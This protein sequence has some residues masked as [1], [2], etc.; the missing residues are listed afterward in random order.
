MPGTL[1]LYATTEG[2]TARIAERIARALR[3]RGHAAETCPAT[4]APQGL[5]AAGYNGVV[6]GASIHYGRHPAYLRSLVRS[7]RAAL[8]ARPS[9]FFSVSLSGGGPGAKP[10]AARRYLEVFLRQ[11]GWHPQQTATFAGALPYSR[12]GAFKRRL[13]VAFVGL[14]GGDTD[15]SRD[16][17]YTDWDAVERFAETFA[18]RLGPA[19]SPGPT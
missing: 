4:D 10:E 19:T 17:E 12:Y 3:N 5:G 6:V 15:T 18:Q 8:E 1:I 11:T 14:G 9:A 16:Y 7:H 13:M 2:Q